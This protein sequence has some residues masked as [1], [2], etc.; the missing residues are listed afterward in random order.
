[1]AEDNLKSLIIET[2]KSFGKKRIRRRQLFNIIGQKNLSYED[3]K[4]VLTDMEKAGTIVR[5][6]GRRFALP[7]ESGNISG[8][9]TMTRNGGGYIRTDDGNTIF[10][11]QDNTHGALTGDKVQAKPVKYTKVGLSPIVKVVAILERSAQPVIGIFKTTGK[12]SYI[13]PRGEEFAGNIIVK[14][15]SELYARDGDLVVARVEMP[16]IGFSRPMCVITEVLGDPDAP[17]VDVLAI[18]KRYGLPVFF[19][20]EVITASRKIPADLTPEVIGTRKDIR[21]LVTFTI[22]PFDAKDFDD[23]VS[24]TKRTDGSYYLGV[25][26]ADVSHYVRED[27]LIDREAQARGMSCYLVD[28]VIPMLPER[29]SNE[30]CS[31]KPDEDRLTKSVFAHLDPEGNITSHELANTVIHSRMRLT[32]EQVQAY[33]DRKDSNEEV[34]KKY[35]AGDITPEVGEALHILSELTDILITRR[36]TRGALDFENPE[37]RIILLL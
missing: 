2:I 22:D 21:S 5:M 10:V 32:Y 36:A 7:E 8:I 1:M 11:R 23:A 6:K 24:I 30:L 15:N 20:E 27:S 14:Q 3:F 16:S 17:G 19:S 26:I 37:A 34:F 33:L 18:A 4:G 31:L 28:R 29:L 25:H 35:G 13:I 12:T 9:F